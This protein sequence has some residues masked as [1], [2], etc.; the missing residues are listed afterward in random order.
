MTRL[1]RRQFLK[2]AFA[3][4]VLAAL[5]GRL[6]AAIRLGTSKKLSDASQLMQVPVQKHLIV[7]KAGDEELIAALRRELKNAAAEKRPVAVSAARHSMGGQS[8]PRDG[9]A[10]TLQDPSFEIDSARKTCRVSAGTR[11]HQVIGHLDK[12]GLSPAVMQSN[13]DFGVGS[14]FCVNAHGWPVPYG[15]FGSTVDAIRLMLHDGT[16]L[17]CSRE[18]NAELFKLSMGGYGLFGIILDLDIGIVENQLLKPTL[19]KMPAEEFA[20]YFIKQATD[21]KVK[22][23]YGRLEVARKTFFREAVAISY[24][25]EPTPEDGLPKVDDGGIVS[26]ISRKVYRAQ[27]GSE[28]AKR[29]RW[30]IESSIAPSLSSGVATRNSLMAEPVANLASDDKSRTDILHEYFVP[31][32]QFPQFVESCRSIIPPSHLE[33]LNVTLRYVAPDPE[34]VLAYAP[35]TRIAAVMSFSQRRSEADEDEMRN[36]TKALID[37]AYKAGGSFYLPYRLHATTD[38]LTSVYPETSRFV[39]RKRHYDPG[40]IFRNL[41]WDQYFTGL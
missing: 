36:V 14:T 32:E 18:E 21:P 16:I 39:Q 23:A 38:Q 41:M 25:P 15:P 1:Y 24:R 7:E 37:A 11:W 31:P 40:L 13:S 12:H 8:L 26:Y 27:I 3:I 10:I 20:A 5:P 28:W 17:R 29:Q 6:R 22:M 2:S 9:I 30:R 4:S 34:S 33:F 19:V 35:T